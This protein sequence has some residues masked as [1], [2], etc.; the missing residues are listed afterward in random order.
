MVSEGL[1]ALKNAIEAVH[2]CKAVHENTQ[3]V[4]GEFPEELAWDGVVECFALE[5]HRSTT[6]CYAWSY[7]KGNEMRH[8]TMLR[9]PPIVSAPTAV[10]VAV[11]TGRMK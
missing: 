7:S 3:T 5:G 6:C 10:R 8:V 11:A 4:N 2:G 9:I 1:E